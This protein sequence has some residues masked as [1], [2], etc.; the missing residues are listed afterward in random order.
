M[1][2]QHVL[3]KT[4]MMNPLMKMIKTFLGIILLILYATAPDVFATANQT[5]ETATSWNID[6]AHSA[7]NFSINHFFTPVD[8][9]FDAYSAE[10]YFDPENL[11]GSSINITIPVESV[12]TRNQR[13]DNH[14]K[15]SDFF[16]SIQWPEIRFVSNYIEHTG[17]N[18]QYVA[19]GELTIR[20]V[21][22]EFELPFELLGV[23]DHP[24]RENVVVA[25]II[26]EASLMR[27][28][29]GVGVGD[30][31]AT[32]VVGDQ[33]NIRINLELTTTR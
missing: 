4:D 12:N 14:L 15:S 18:N 19:K 24:M 28:D 9:N 3:K 16:N 6:R 7:I 13:R 5:D 25:G 23:M 32:A 33:V 11:A 17:N 1:L 26:S 10:I 21:T 27:T 22:R 8:G 30:W 31:A 2:A 29:F 20:D